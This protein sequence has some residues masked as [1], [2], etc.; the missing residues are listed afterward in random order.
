MA[1]ARRP[2]D[3]RHARS[4]AAAAADETETEGANARDVAVVVV[5]DIVAVRPSVRSSVD[6]H[7]VRI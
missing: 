7:A 1:P 6:A 4:T 2:L 3:V 5:V